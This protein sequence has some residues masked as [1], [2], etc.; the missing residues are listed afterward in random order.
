MIRPRNYRQGS[1]IDP[2]G[3]LGPKRR[4]L[5]ENSWAGLFRG[6]ILAELPVEQL[7]SCFRTDFGRPTKDLQTVLGVLVLQQM[8]DLTDLETVNQLAFNQQWHYALDI[9]SESDAAKYMCPKTLWTMRHKVTDQELDTVLFHQVADKL[10]QVFEVDTAKQRL[11]SVH[12]KSNM[13]KLGRLGILVRCISSFLVNLKRRHP[14]LY[15]GLDP[16]LA[17]RYGTKKALACFSQVKPSD[18]AKTLAEVAQEAWDLVEGFAQDPQVGAMKSYLLLQRAFN[19]HCEV[20]TAGVDAPAEVTVKPAKQVSS[21]SLQNPSDPDAAYSGH[22]GQGYHA[23]V[24]E[25]YCDSEDPQVKA[26]TLNLI[27]HVAVAPASESDSR[28]LLPAITDTQ[29]RD[30]GPQEVLADAAYGSDDNCQE[31]AA[32]STKVEVVAPLPGLPPGTGLSLSDFQVSPAGQVLACPKGQA[33]RSCKCRKHRY[34]VAFASEQCNACPE[35]SRCPVQPAK[36]YH[37]LS[38][39]EK[40]GRVAARRAYQQT[41]EFR[42]RYRWRAGI[43]GAMSEYDR[44][45]GVK[46]LRVRGLKAVRFC[47][48]LKAV[49]VNLFRATKVRRA[50]NRAGNAGPGAPSP[51][52]WLVSRVKEQITAFGTAIID[53]LIPDSYY[54]PFDL[55]MAI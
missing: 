24:M 14:E 26:R 11:D 2:W 55:K 42:H 41:E 13:R 40:A 8:H 38:Y 31:A 34:R 53:C 19:D 1:L 45:T 12:L 43:E 10:A 46:R 54:N 32:L 39:Y 22:K 29:A 4:R 44:L 7:A 20:K 3:D 48:T 36:K 25:T 51:F 50:K 33:P 18:S 15:G 5:L 6:E 47:V 35:K 16:K 30:L 21:Q 27:T 52:S 37:Y 49:G 23:Q 28:A 17:A 9:P